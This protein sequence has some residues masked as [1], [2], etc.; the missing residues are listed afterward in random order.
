MDAPWSSL[1]KTSILSWSVRVLYFPP[2][3]I[4]IDR[5]TLLKTNIHCSRKRISFRLYLCI[6][7]LSRPIF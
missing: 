3:L 1:F 6:T 5:N 7:T 2:V 4:L